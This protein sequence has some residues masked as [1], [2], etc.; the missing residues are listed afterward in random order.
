MKQRRKSTKKGSQHTNL[1]RKSH[2]TH[3][4][5]FLHLCILVTNSLLVNPPYPIQANPVNLC[6]RETLNSIYSTSCPRVVV[7]LPALIQI[8]ISTPAALCSP[9]LHLPRPP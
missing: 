7:F 4:L 2:G 6:V 3:L 8:P 1:K 5:E 9:A